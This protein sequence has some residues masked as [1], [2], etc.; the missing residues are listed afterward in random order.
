MILPKAKRRIK[1][2]TV[3]KTDGTGETKKVYV[4][5]AST[6]TVDGKTYYVFKCGVAAKDMTAEISAQMIDGEKSGTEYKYSV[7]EYAKEILDHPDRYFTDE[8]KRRKGVA[9]VKAMLNY[10]SYAQVYF[11]PDI[12]N[13]NDFRTACSYLD[14]DPYIVNN[15]N[16]K[17]ISYGVVEPFFSFLTA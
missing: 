3:T 15:V 8:E 9:L 6:A 2:F 13:I 7:R 1:K 11:D 16:A 14:T 10:G 12:G 4:K 17:T 5:D